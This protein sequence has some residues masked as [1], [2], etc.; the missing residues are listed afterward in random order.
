MFE[1][2]PQAKKA[3]AQ[4]VA[5]KLRAGGFEALWAG[6]CVRDMLRGATP[7]DFDVATNAS[8]EQATR[9]FNRTCQVGASF[10]VVRVIGPPEAGDVEIATFR[11]DGAYV[12]GRRPSS[13]HF[14][15]ARDDASR[16]DFTINGMFMDPETEAVIDYVGGR[17]DLAEGVLRAIGKPI[18]RFRE[19]RLRLVR[20]VRF[21]ARFN[22]VIE[23]ETLA[24]LTSMMPSA[25][26]VAQERIATELRKMLVDPNRVLA[27][28][29]G[30]QTGFNAAV[31]P[32]LLPMKGLPQE[33]PAQPNGDLWDHT[34]L[35][36]EKLGEKPSFTLAFASLYHDIGKPR[37]KAFLDGRT[38]FHN[39]E[40]VGKAIADRRA[41]A[42]KLSNGERERINW[43]VEYHQYLGAPRKMR[44]A[45]LKRM[46]AMP[47]IDELLS[48]HRADALASWGDASEI[49]YLEHYL[50]HEPAGP[51][52]PPAIISG[53]DL[54]RQGLTPGPSFKEML[55]EVRELQLERKLASKREA[56]EWIEGRL[57][58]GRW[59]DARPSARTSSHDEPQSR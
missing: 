22:L 14:G 10:G 5:R 23:P 13:V 37:T 4:E 7:S 51:I 18:E 39:H 16:R 54:A 6:G 36:L 32:E 44:E 42:L 38:T 21:A 50:K 33:K 58:E 12:D 26:S 45:T 40:Q 2:K 17:N 48:L 30:D 15:N 56:L 1:V 31:L 9:L 55:D 41:R 25:T 43:L 20:A 8:P 46:L 35:V 57:A 24:A 47:G 27:L 19:D 34:L 53:H 49:D 52:N 59:T 11:S 28:E 29:I 3:F